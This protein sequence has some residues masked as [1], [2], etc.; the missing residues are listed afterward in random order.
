MVGGNFLKTLPDPPAA[1]RAL[2]NVNTRVHQDVVFSS[3]MLLPPRDTVLVFPATTRYESAGGGTETSTERRIIFS[4]E[5][6]GRRI[7]SARPECQVFGDVMARVSPARAAQIQFSSAQQIR[8]EIARAVPLYR[9]IETLHVKGDQ[10][11][12][13]G[14]MLYA[15]GEFATPDGKAH[16][17]VTR[18]LGAQ[19]AEAAETI[20]R[21]DSASSAPTVFRVSTR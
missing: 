19:Y 15:D 1:A 13:G 16:F 7:G 9:G 14:P 10:I 3:M 11:Q 12:W 17:S 4:P 2:K 21:A 5:I 18:R 6:P 20:G 8:D